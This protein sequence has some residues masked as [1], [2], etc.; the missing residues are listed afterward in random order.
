M[1]PAIRKY[2]A[3][4]QVML[5]RTRL[6][7]ISRNYTLKTIFLSVADLFFQCFP[8]SKVEVK[9][10]EINC[11]LKLNSKASRICVHVQ[12]FFCTLLKKL[13]LQY[14]FRSAI[15]FKFRFFGLSNDPNEISQVKKKPL[16]KIK[17][18]QRNGGFNKHI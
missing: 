9:I 17:Y 1:E 5:I 18:W 16:K 11:S 15:F 2:C 14:T 13:R 4:S 6:F 12:R 10:A 8:V 7:R 3:R